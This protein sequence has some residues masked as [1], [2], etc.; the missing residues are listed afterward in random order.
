MSKPKV[1][2]SIG[3]SAGA[4][5]SMND[6]RRKR[7]GRSVIYLVPLRARLKGNAPH[8]ILSPANRE[9]P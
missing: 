6:G 9:C 7:F 4:R 1:V 3:V 8:C 5:L 2:G